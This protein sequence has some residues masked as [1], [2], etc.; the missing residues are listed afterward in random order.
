LGER[1]A[2]FQN[3]WG[4][5]G[6]TLFLS[7]LKHWFEPTEMSQRIANRAAGHWLEYRKGY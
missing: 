4:K 3:E 5:L 2:N 6:R 1:G 7:E